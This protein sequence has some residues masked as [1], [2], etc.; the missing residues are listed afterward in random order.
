MSPSVN[1]SSWHF[2]C[3]WYIAW[4]CDLAGYAIDNPT[5]HVQYHVSTVCQIHVNLC[6]QV[7]NAKSQASL[8][9]FTSSCKS[10]TL[11]SKSSLQSLPAWSCLPCFWRS[12]TNYVTQICVILTHPTHMTYYGDA[13]LVNETNTIGLPP[14]TVVKI[15]LSQ[16][17]PS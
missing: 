12:F 9:S 3:C 17:R 15:S 10:F 7:S 6:T 5:A 11:S 8:K 14:S 1:Q 2:F 16:S 13:F 4:S